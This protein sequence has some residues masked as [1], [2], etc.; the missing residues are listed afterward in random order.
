MSDLANGRVILKF[1]N[2]VLVQKSSF[3]LYNN[4][5]ISLYKVYQ[6]NNCLR[7]PTNNFPP[8]NCS[9]GTVKLIRNI[10]KNKFTYNGQGIEFD[11]TG[12]WSVYNDYARNVVIFGVDN[13]SSSHTDMV[14]AYV[15][16]PLQ[17]I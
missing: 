5:I 4:F 17:L 2:S 14:R 6:L 8:K 3:S 7:N 9:F 1:K 11:K 16:I 13:S 15:T 12:S 10:I